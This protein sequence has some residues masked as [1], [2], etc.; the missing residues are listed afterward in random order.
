MVFAQVSPSPFPPLTYQAVLKG[1]PKSAYSVC[2]VRKV[3]LRGVEGL[4]A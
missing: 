1:L 2:Q 4:D 3:V